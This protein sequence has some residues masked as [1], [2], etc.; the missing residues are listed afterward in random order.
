MSHLIPSGLEVTALGFHP[1]LSK[2]TLWWALEWIV[3]GWLLGDSS[4]TLESS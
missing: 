1:R 3:Q 2:N 4:S